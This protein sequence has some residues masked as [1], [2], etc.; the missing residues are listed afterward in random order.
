M[1]VVKSYTQEHLEANIAI[2]K[3]L[4]EALN[5]VKTA[6][7]KSKRKAAKAEMVEPVEPEQVEVTQ[8]S[9][10]IPEQAE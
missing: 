2:R 3:E 4:R 7:A 10:D 8:D 6:P 9:E 1:A 5:R